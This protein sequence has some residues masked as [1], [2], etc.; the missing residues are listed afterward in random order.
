MA[1]DHQK[2]VRIGIYEC[3]VDGSFISKGKW[4][5]GYYGLYGD[6]LLDSMIIPDLKDAKRAGWNFDF[7]VLVVSYC[8]GKGDSPKPLPRPPGKL[9][10]KSAGGVV[11]LRRMLGI[12]VRRKKIPETETWE[13]VIDSQG[14]VFEVEGHKL[15]GS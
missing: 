10:V 7:P 15:K 9:S 8:L 1:K 11:A 14:Q 13:V 5:K 12:P 4:V 3:R 6:D 2:S